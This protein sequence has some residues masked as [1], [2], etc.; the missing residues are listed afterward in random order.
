MDKNVYGSDTHKQK[1]YQIGKAS[2][3]SNKFN[4]R[5][6]ASGEIYNSNLYTAAHRSLPFGTRVK[7]INI[8]NGKFVIVKINDRGAFR[9]DRII[10]VSRAAAKKLG[11]IREG[12]I[13]V[14]IE[15][16]SEAE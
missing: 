14:K 12:I 13:K 6:T 15:I 8:K 11:M 2:Y 10:D 16:V 5:K 1:L 7:V 3:Y 9:G 4:G